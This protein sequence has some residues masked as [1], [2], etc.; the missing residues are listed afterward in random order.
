M[1]HGLRG[2]AGAA[3]WR[4]FT[5]R[6]YY[7][8]VRRIAGKSGLLKFGQGFHYLPGQGVVC[9]KMLRDFPALR[10][11]AGTAARQFVCELKEFTSVQR[12]ITIAGLGPALLVGCAVHGSDRVAFY[13]TPGEAH[14]APAQDVPIAYRPAPVP[15][16]RPLIAQF[17]SLTA[18]FKGKV[19]IA[20][21]SVDDG[22]LAQSNGNL[23]LP[24]QSVSKLWVTMTVLDQRD[25]GRLTL[26]DPISVST[27]D[28]TVF[29]QPIAA[30]VKP[31]Q[32]YQTSIGEL[33]RRAMQMS[34]N[35]C[36]DKLLR[37]VGGPDAVRD[38]I[39]RKGLGAIGF[40]PGEKLLQA[41]TAGLPWRPEYSRGNAFAVARA[42]LPAGV[43]LAAFEAYVASPPDGASPS[44]IAGALARLKRGD[45]LS[46]SSTAWLMSTMEG[47][48]TGKQRLRGAVPPGWTFGHKTGTGQDLAGRTAGYNDVGFLIAPDGRSYAMAV[49]I[50]DTPRPIKERQ[51]LMQAVVAAVVANHR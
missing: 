10:E 43:R 14:A 13:I 20:V 49:M 9:V 48:H 36:N 26:D 41:G 34:D 31:G 27:E 5:F 44:A 39:R 16:P 24:Q 12:A 40:G 42:K 4:P 50:G 38:F 25:Q 11:K 28:F 21:T 19:G 7:P 35:T 37:Y 29:H 2:I 8:R 22:W 18:G 1:Q 32:P 15:A 17:Q 47:S 30:L 46:P 45:L 6:R 51:E 33:M 3:V 23:S